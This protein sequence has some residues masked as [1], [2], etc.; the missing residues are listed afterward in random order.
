LCLPNSTRTLIINNCINVM[1]GREINIKE[2]FFEQSE[3]KFPKI[4]GL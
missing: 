3:K 2:M 4:L 1:V